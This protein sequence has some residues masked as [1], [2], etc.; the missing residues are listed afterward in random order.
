[1]LTSFLPFPLGFILALLFLLVGSIKLLTD[2]LI[3]VD[4][5]LQKV[6]IKQFQDLRYI[7][8][9]AIKDIRTKP[10]FTSDDGILMVKSMSLFLS[11]ID[12]D[13]TEIY[14]T[15]RL[16]DLKRVAKRIGEITEKRVRVPHDYYSMMSSGDMTLRA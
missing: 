14:T 12:G 16:S 2:K 4:K 13:S 10:T 7:P 6:V 3:S 1:M 11:T 15:E 5:T 9:D 8:F